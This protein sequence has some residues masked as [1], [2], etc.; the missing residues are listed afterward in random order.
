MFKTFDQELPSARIIYAGNW[1]IYGINEFIYTKLGIKLTSYGY[2]DMIMSTEPMRYI[3]VDILKFLND[4][5]Y[6]N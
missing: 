6:E 1:H 3:E 2:I 4:E 5:W